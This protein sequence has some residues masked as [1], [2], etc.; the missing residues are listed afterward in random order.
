MS[1]WYTY[2]K[3]NK[4]KAKDKKDK[5]IG[6]Y[7]IDP[8]GMPPGEYYDAGGYLQLANEDREEVIVKESSGQPQEN[9][10]I[11]EYVPSLAD[12]KAF[13]ESLSGDEQT[14]SSY[15]VTTTDKL[16]F[17]KNLKPATLDKEFYEFLIEKG[18]EDAIEEENVFDEKTTVTQ[19]CVQY[20]PSSLLNFLNPFLSRMKAVDEESKRNIEQLKD[21]L[22]I[23]YYAEK[24][25]ESVL[26]CLTE[27]I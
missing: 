21:I 26:F 11:D 25:Q 12:E 20:N 3:K 17:A 15:I 27:R 10:E 4:N 5:V 16:K 8:E 18:I 6:P 2:S 23:V 7:I 13:D 14:A 24:V 9:D 19:T 22:K 1:N